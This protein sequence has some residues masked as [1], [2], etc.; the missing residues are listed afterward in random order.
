MIVKSNF[1]IH[2]SNLNCGV[3]KMADEITKETEVSKLLRIVA[4]RGW[5][6]ITKLELLELY[7]QSRWSA[8]I[9]EDLQFRWKKSGYH[10][11]WKKSK[12]A[13]C[14]PHGIDIILVV[15]GENYWL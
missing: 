7:D 3:F 14:D 10:A 13:F 5:A 2:F 12:L 4:A 9:S 1:D 8:G 15:E 11:K 6:V